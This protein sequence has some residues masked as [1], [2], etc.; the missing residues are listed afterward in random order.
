MWGALPRT[1]RDA[2]L[3]ARCGSGATTTLGCGAGAQR[4]LPAPHHRAGVSACSCPRHGE[5]GRVPGRAQE[6]CTSSRG[7]SR[8]ALNATELN[9]K[10]GE[11]LEYDAEAQRWA[12]ELSEGG[13][14]RVRAP[15]L[16]VLSRDDCLPSLHAVVMLSRGKIRQESGDGE[17]AE[18]ALGKMA[19][20]DTTAIPLDLQSST[21]R[22]AV[23]VLKQRA[24]V[25][26]DDK[27]LV[28]IHS[29]TQLAVHGQTDKGDRG[30]IAAG[31]VRA[32]KERLAKLDDQKLATF[33]I[34]RRYAAHART[35]AAN[36]ASWGLIPPL[37][38]PSL[39]SPG[40]AHWGVGRAAGG[41]GEVRGERILLGD[42]GRM[43]MSAG[44][45][46]DTVGGQYQQALDMCEF[47]L[48]C[49]LAL[50]GNDSPSVADSF[51]NMANVYNDQ[52]KYEEALEMHAESLAI[53]T[54]IYGDNHPLVADSWN[55]IGEVLR[56]TGK[57]E[58]ALEMH[59]KSLEL[60]TRIYGGDSHPLVADSFN[61]LGVV[62]ERKGDLENAL[63]HH[64]K[65][66]EIKLKLLG[67][68]HPLVATSFYNLGLVYEG[69]GDFENALVQ[70]QKALEIRT[71][72][73]GSAHPLVAMSFNNI[74]VVYRCMG[75]LENALVQ[76]QKALE[77]RTQVFGSEH[78]LVADSLNNLGIV[79]GK[80]GNT[81]AATE[82]NTKTY[83]IYLKV[84]GP[85]HP[86]T[87]NLKPFVDE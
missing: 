61:N 5:S 3:R 60:R 26:V 27:D 36:A 16:V 72:V 24:L 10:H 64:Q 75:D 71:R 68:E 7:Q 66:L 2:G 81:A 38:F 51:N 14:I 8:A 63:V 59:A 15:N 47:A 46:F 11:L 35:A 17:A 22:K 83:H 80:M 44:L 54:R 41:G 48:V 31:V 77:I 70:N 13:S 1:R 79:Y 25:T 57:Y 20:L 56:H 39:A 53:R 55:N 86:D 32:L 23:L 52:G 18:A 62:Y 33:V 21:E 49:A 29:L 9:G 43:C 6:G 28:A 30:E 82:M 67:S 34:G 19:L 69:K 12:V 78:P 73:F 76:H 84:L 4:R 87:Q 42:V 74:G 85:D 40:A 37:K 45:F 50:E 65:G 58:E